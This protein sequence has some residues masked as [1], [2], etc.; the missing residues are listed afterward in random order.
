MTNALI[1][2]EVNLTCVACTLALMSLWIWQRSACW[3]VCCARAEPRSCCRYGPGYQ[4]ARESLDRHTASD[5][6]SQPCSGVPNALQSM[7]CR[8]LLC[9]CRCCSRAG[10]HTLG[11]FCKHPQPC[12]E[13]LRASVQEFDASYNLLSDD[14]EHFLILT[15]AKRLTLRCTCLELLLTLY[16]SSWDST[17]HHHKV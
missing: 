2:P 16:P 7:P 4:T 15:F 12:N 5:V 11:I 13:T 10:C 1:S 3:S 17:A 6:E 9:C 14:L 8:A